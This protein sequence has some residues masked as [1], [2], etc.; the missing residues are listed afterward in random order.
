MCEGR[1]SHLPWCKLL[2]EDDPALGID[3][4]SGIDRS[5]DKVPGGEPCVGVVGQT[6]SELSADEL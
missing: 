4:C 2:E 6:V 5:R 3:L 1:G